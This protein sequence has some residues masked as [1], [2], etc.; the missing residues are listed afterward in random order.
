MI[1]SMQKRFIS[2][3]L[4]VL[5]IIPHLS[6]F[7]AD[8]TAVSPDRNKISLIEA[9]GMIDDYETMADE[10]GAEE[11][12]KAFIPL[13]YGFDNNEYGAP[14]Y[15]NALRLLVKACGYQFM[16]DDG[17]AY[18]QIASEIGLLKG[19]SSVS[20]L[21]KQTFC[22][23]LI[24]ALDVS[25][26]ETFISAGK[27]SY[28]LS[29]KDTLLS[30]RFNVYKGRGTVTGNCITRLDG[31][32]AVSKGY[33]E[34]DGREVKDKTDCCRDFLGQRIEFYYR[35]ADD[36]P[37]LLTAFADSNCTV[38]AIKAKDIDGYKNN[39]YTYTQ[40]NKTKRIRVS[41]KASIIYN[42]QSYNELSDFIPE[43]GEVIL[44]D[45][46]G[47]GVAE[48]LL[49][50]EYSTWIVSDTD[51]DSNR[52]ILKNTKTEKTR[53][54]DFDNTEQGIEYEIFASGRNVS[55]DDLRKDSI[56][57]IY[58]SRKNYTLIYVCEKYV[59][60]TLE[61]VDVN[62]KT[63][64]IDGI[65]Y[66]IAD[67]E[68][69]A[70]HISQSGKYYIDMA[71]TIVWV[72]FYGKDEFGYLI[73]VWKTEDMSEDGIGVKLLCSDGQI[74]KLICK[75]KFCLN[76]RKIYPNADISQ[77]WD[78]SE[79]SEFNA[80]P[81]MYRLNSDDKI[82]HIFTAAETGGDDDTFRVSHSL[83]TRWYNG[84]LCAFMDTRS[85]LDFPQPMNVDR[86]TVIFY[87]PEDIGDEKN[88]GVGNMSELVWDQLA[89]SV[90]YR[91]TKTNATD[92]IVVKG[93]DSRYENT[94]L[95]ERIFECVSDDKEVVKAIDG[96]VNGYEVQTIIADADKDISGLN[97][98]DFIVWYKNRLG[99][100]M[101]YKKCFDS[102]ADRGLIPSSTNNEERSVYGEVTDFESG[103][104]VINGD[105][106]VRYEYN[107]SDCN[108]VYEFSRRGKKSAKATLGDIHIGDKIYMRLNQERIRM[109]VI[110]KD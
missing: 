91:A 47:N 45:N 74:R 104:A 98:G 56:L 34:I 61:S 103:I 89:N 40:N 51:A 22:K 49:V 92:L 15:E 26:P 27:T 79:D 62:E 106:G 50:Y 82:T 70:K 48:V 107:I 63:A 39:T 80:K 57:T 110:Y 87:I 32:A 3:V 88:Y 2:A 30:V 46:D 99:Q 54:F 67:A 55:I 14:T 65:K 38:T 19:A 58:E 31:A 86:E 59:S 12:K 21:N 1:K 20:P 18:S 16:A 101:D 76:G 109:I 53:K 17:K 73:N 37:E 24:N 52:L 66:D 94:L 108:T 42:G 84:S 100:L 71:G 96:L 36:S 77:M 60:G 93:N 8:N 41:N 75:E 90:G 35:D 85:T 11:F 102:V 10:V 81:V 83:Q 97:S 95:I 29:F 4:A 44:I 6:V 64:Q 72:S 78:F 13:F 28:K 23:L 9:L 5:M 69:F 68:T 43:T 25:Y 33:V 7:A 105:N